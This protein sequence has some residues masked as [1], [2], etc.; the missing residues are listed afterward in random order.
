MSTKLSYDLASSEQVIADLGARLERVRL[1]Q[2]QTQAQIARQ[3]GVSS[4]TVV[5]LEKGEAPSLDTFVRIMQALGLSSYLEAVIPDSDVRPMER[6]QN[7]GHE[8]RRARPT[9]PATRGPFK[10]GD[11]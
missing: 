10:W 11:S 9:P 5:R 3:A 7:R 8:R 1:L 6:V 4:R 2:N